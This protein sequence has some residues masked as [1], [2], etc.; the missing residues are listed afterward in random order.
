MALQRLLCLSP[1][2]FVG[3]LPYLGYF[4]KKKME[5]EPTEL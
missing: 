4:L 5:I 1:R 3:H 2:A